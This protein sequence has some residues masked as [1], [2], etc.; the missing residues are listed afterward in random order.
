MTINIFVLK[1]DLNGENRSG[2]F[3]FCRVYKTIK[4]I[5][6]YFLTYM[7]WAHSIPSP[8]S[9]RVGGRYARNTGQPHSQVCPG[10]RVVR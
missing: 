7:H 3:L 8:D 10:K 9:R 1:G 2:A 6:I 5:R 4:L